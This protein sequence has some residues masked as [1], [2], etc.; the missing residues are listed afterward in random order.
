MDFS[1][2]D[3]DL[4]VTLLLLLL[5]G[6]GPKIALVPFLEKTKHLEPAIQRSVGR[7]TVVTAVVTAIV[8]FATGALLM[9][10][11]HITAGTVAV[12]GAIILAILAIEMVAAPGKKV[13]EDAGVQAE[14]NRVA[15]YPLAVP[16]LLNPVGITIMIVAS[17]EVVSIA[18]AGLVLGLILLVGAFDYLVFSNIDKL[19]MRL[20]PVS[21]I[22]S[23][24]VFGILLTAVAV[25]MMV[26][27]LGLLGI[28][29][30]AK[31]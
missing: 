11:L 16:Y 1:V 7:R 10:L 12:A 22:I 17:G 21:L 6:M 8:L 18:S 28:I 25:E 27:G 30:A 24:V 19:A 2:I 9:R 26:F 13:E 14:P 15:I 4:V 29:A 31:H 23:E 5:I 3:V 20:N